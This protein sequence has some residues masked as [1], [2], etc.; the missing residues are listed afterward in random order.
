MEANEIDKYRIALKKA[1]QKINELDNALKEAKKEKEV[2]I[3]GYQCRFPGGANNTQLFWEKLVQG[4][5]AVTEIKKE[6]FPADLYYSEDS[7]KEGKMFTKYASFLEKDVYEFDNTHFEISPVEAGCIDPQHRLLLE[8]SWEALEDAGIN[9]ESIKGSK[10]GVFIGVDSTDYVSHELVSGNVN[11][12][13]P[14]S[15]VGVSPHSAAGRISYFYDFKGPAASIGTACSSSLTAMNMAVDSLKNGQCDLAIVGGVNIMLNPEPYIGLS[16]FHG[17]SPDGRCKTF[18]ASA[19]GFGRG[20]GCGIIILKRLDDARRDKNNIEAI[21]RSIYVGHDG[22]SNG[23][24]APN[25]LAEQRV[26]QEAR[27]NAKLNED[28][29]DYIEAHGTGTSLGD[30]IEAQAVCEAFKGRKSPI[31][32]GA[33]K[34]NIGHLEAAAGMASV[35][36]VLLSLKYKQIPPSIHFKDPNPNIDWSKIQVV[37]K[38]M[39]WEKSN[40]KRRAGINAFGISGT[41]VHVIL[42]EDDIQVK[43]ETDVKDAIIT[44]STKSKNALN[45]GINEIKEYINS[46]AESL[47][48][49]AYSTNI[50]KD[51]NEYRFAVVGTNKEQ[52]IEEINQALKDEETKKFYI[53]RSVGRKGKVAYL[54]TGQG[55]IYKN[56]AKN[57]YDNSK[58]F[59]SAFDKCNDRFNELLNI[60]VKR[61]LFNEEEDQLTNALYSQAVIF[62]LEYSL[63]KIWDTTGIKPDYVIG[64]SVGEYVAMCYSG[65]IDFMDATK[66]IALRAKLMTN[67]KPNGKMVGVLGEPEM[68]QEAIDASGCKNVSI[69]AINAPKNVTISGIK[70]EVD[71]VVDEIHKK[72]RVFI[73]D[74]GILYPYHSAAMKEYTPIYGDLLNDIKCNKSKIKVISTVTGK[75]EEKSTFEV[76]DY[77]L[78]HLEKTVHFTKAMQTAESLGVTT[79]IEIGGTATLSGLA[80]Q[81]IENKEAIFVPS[82]RKGVGEYRQLLESLK[83][84]YLKG[85]DIDWKGFYENYSNKKVGLPNYPFER[86]PFGNNKPLR[87][88]DTKEDITCIS[89]LLELQ[90]KQITEQQKILKSIYKQND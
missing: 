79:F 65:T 10:T 55:S 69:A 59:R 6:R 36:K 56:V 50:V 49:I 83:Q 25:G 76:K 57:L 86:K 44:I 30:F 8:V 78:E 58:E 26:I 24:F 63:T 68:I 77:W 61:A 48:D 43:E 35:I 38:L 88:N 75:L 21:V 54:F 89:K 52:V 51:K 22:K 4:F 7:S 32:I 13:K 71:L 20:E 37:D 34:S 33:V 47:R 53:G 39:N 85:I 27:K 19:D 5:D 2:A 64:H 90:N 23:F 45:K 72:K 46:S 66:M 60:S 14:Y 28:E 42:E 74:L 73:N 87:T 80:N 1:A 17:L 16:Q 3:I 9:I 31:K 15:L 70:D 81:C 11:D 18:D 84:L 29:I 40:N 67:V 62:S 82:L 41:L 12:I